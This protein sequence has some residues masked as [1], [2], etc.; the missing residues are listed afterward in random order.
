MKSRKK[1]IILVLSIIIIFS[2]GLLVN[3]IMTNNKDTAKQKKEN[4]RCC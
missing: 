1:G 3:N 4:R 2:I